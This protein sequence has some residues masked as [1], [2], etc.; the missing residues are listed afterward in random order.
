MKRLMILSAMPMALLLFSCGNETAKD[1]TKATDT[2]ATAA[3]QAAEVKPVFTPF[4][5][6]T[7]QPKV[8]NYEKWI[9]T[10]YAD[11]SLRKSYGITHVMIGRDLKDTNMLYAL[12]K[13][14]DME[15]ARTY[16][17]LT[18]LKETSKAAGLVGSLGFSYGEI[19]RN[20]DS[21]TD[22]PDRLGVA[23][24]VKDYA[25][26]LKV[27][28]AQGHAA[29]RAANGM[30]DRSIARGLIDSNMV[31]LIFVVTDMEKA[32]ARMASDSIKNIMK[33]SG[34]DSPPTIRWYRVVK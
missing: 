5:V 33:E 10:Y 13:M 20:D 27:F 7:I 9:K 24:H 1:E 34:V 14:E 6:V 16:S 31:Y 22:F 32:K 19:V 17:K 2:A 29:T 12:A 15:K 30:L 26:W 18:N 4:K 25:A 3:A 23:H 21:P 28:D 11:D 8:K